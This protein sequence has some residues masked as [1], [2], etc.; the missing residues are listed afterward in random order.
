MALLGLLFY[1][2]QPILTAATLE[3]VG[4][5][6]ATTG[7]GIVYFSAFLMAPTSPRTAV[8]LYEDVSVNAA[9]CYIV[10]LFALAAVLFASLPLGV[11][12]T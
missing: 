9:L 3:A 12:K 4:R 7:L 1:P 11:D 5:E 2:G 10:G 6:V 8:G